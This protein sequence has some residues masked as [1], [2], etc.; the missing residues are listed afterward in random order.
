[1][2][3]KTELCQNVW[4]FFGLNLKLSMWQEVLI[5]ERVHMSVGSSQPSKVLTWDRGDPGLS[6]RLIQ[7]RVFILNHF[8]SGREDLNVSPSHQATEGGKNQQSR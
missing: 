5:P 8:D 2:F 7:S 4:G 1:M 3:T 6:P